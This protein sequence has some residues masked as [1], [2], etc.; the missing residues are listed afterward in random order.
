MME[1]ESSLANETLPTESSL[2]L[3][4]A[5]CYGHCTFILGSNNSYNTGETIRWKSCSDTLEEIFSK[6]MT[7]E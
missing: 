5:T 6:V 4:T 2:F 1:E 7:V 3:F